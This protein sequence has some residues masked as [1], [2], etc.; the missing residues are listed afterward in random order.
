[1]LL[2]KILLSI[3]VSSIR[4]RGRLAFTLHR[5]LHREPD[6]LGGGGCP[7][8]LVHHCRGCVRR[9]RDALRVRVELWR[10]CRFCQNECRNRPRTRKRSKF[11][12]MLSLVTRPTSGRSRAGEQCRLLWLRQVKNRA[13][14]A[15][16]AV[17]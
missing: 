2:K 1:M 14:A 11:D 17:W 16:M 9:V 5:Q 7:T 10:L 6:G 8:R 13:A 3:L 15:D 4:T 12:P